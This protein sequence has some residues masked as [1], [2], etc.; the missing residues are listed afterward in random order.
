MPLAAAR[1]SGGWLGRPATVQA[2]RAVQWPAKRSRLHVMV[3]IELPSDAGGLQ[4][5]V[6]QSGAPRGSP[7][8]QR[9]S[10]LKV[11]E[12]LARIRARAARP[13]LTS[14]SLLGGARLWPADL[15]EHV[16]VSG[17]TVVAAPPEL[18]RSGRA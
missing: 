2:P 4:S 13:D 17:D 6:G 3:L 7:M 12:L 11:Q 8:V 14:L 10:G 15:V 9:A 18:T 1:S 16:L 5:K